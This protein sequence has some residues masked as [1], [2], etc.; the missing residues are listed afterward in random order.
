MNIGAGA[1]ALSPVRVNSR[2]YTESVETATGTLYRLDRGYVAVSGPGSR[3]L[4]RAD[5]LERGRLA[6]ARRGAARAAADAEEPDRR[7]L[8]RRAR[9]AG[10]V[11]A[12]HGVGARG[13]RRVDAAA[14]PLRGQVR[15]RA[16]SRIAATCSSAAGDGIRT[17][18]TA[19]RPSR[20]GPRVSARRPSRTS[21]SSACASRPARP[22]GARARRDHPARRGRARRDARLLHQ[23]LLS[24]PGADRAAALS[25][26]AEPPPAGARG[27]SARLAT[28]SS[29][30]R[31]RS[32]V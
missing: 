5:G 24:G 30:A 16:R 23:G 4:P 32:A 2:P 3:G 10:D 7:A 26:P 8:A 22:S 9:G 15:G 20:A 27:R 19:S 12:D 6:R 25:R 21:S 17:A 28:R 11:S 31:R 1:P 29:W 18:T 14:R 13:D